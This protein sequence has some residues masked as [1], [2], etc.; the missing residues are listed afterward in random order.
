MDNG[1]HDRGRRAFLK[2]SAALA[3]AAGASGLAPAFAQSYPDRNIDVIIPT[4]E[5]GGADRLFRAF[6][7]VWKNYLN[8]N[9]EP[10]FYPG[11]SGRVGYEVY[12]GK[13]EPDAYSLIFGNMGPELA[14]WV[15]Q[16]PDYS[17]PE[18]FQYFCRLD[19]DPSTLFVAADS[20]FQTVDD[21]VA[22]A[23]KRSLNVATSR[24]PH[25]ATIGA[26]L[27]AEHTGAQFNMVPLSG[28]RN[29]LAGVVTGEMDF[30][31]LPSGSVVSAGESVRTLA[32]WDDKNPYP[33]KLNDAPTVN[34][35][36]G[37]S[38]PPL[39]SA[40]AFGI[41]T[42][43]M[44]EYPERFEVLNKTAK[45]AFDDPAWREA[46]KEAGQPLEILN[47]GDLEACNKYAKGMIE[48]ARRYKDLLTGKA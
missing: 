24:L 10:G 9:L 35:H 16:E 8:T 21:V 32:V 44:E 4:R 19:S 41:H 40:R 48:V 36:F 38:F 25:P 2:S 46:A 11:A 23:K 3:A 29:T 33:D 22:E 17:F 31:V 26:L 13:N 1:N 5:G 27:L 43:A 34:D 6:S 20:P 12:I 42:K 14:V 45:Q 30:G 37:T 47:Y 28:G 18:D 39:V 15:V 7:G